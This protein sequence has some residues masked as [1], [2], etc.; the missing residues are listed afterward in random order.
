MEFE[1]PFWID[2]ED[3]RVDITKRSVRVRVTNE[4]DTIRHFWWK[5]EG[6]EELCKNW[7]AI[8][9]EECAWSLDDESINSRGEKCRVLMI[10]FAKPSPDQEEREYKKNL[11]QD[12]RFALAKWVETPTTQE[13]GVRF[14][15]EDEDDFDFESLLISMVFME[16]GSSF[17]PAKPEHAY[18]EPFDTSKTISDVNLLPKRVKTVLEKLLDGAEAFEKKNEEGGGGG[19]NLEAIANE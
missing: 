5:T 13:T 14:F 4:I 18:R 10:C 1:L 2:E 12:N 11:R 15:I 8:V 7:Q 6:H 3:V 9:P 16:T 19:I 17:V